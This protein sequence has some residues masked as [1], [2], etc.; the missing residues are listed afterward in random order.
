LDI[1]T[2]RGAGFWETSA[3]ALGGYRLGFERNRFRGFAGLEA[4]VGMVAQNVDGGTARLS[5]T[6]VGAPWLVA[7]GRLSGR[8]SLGLEGHLPVGW[9]RRD[10]KDALVLLPA[11]WI[12]ILIQ[13]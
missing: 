1:S 5:A 12:G 13:L 4:G 6:F 9:I 8:L 10:G 7:S 11:G 2:S 3:L